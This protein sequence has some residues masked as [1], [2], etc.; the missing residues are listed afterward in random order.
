MNGFSVEELEA[1]IRGDPLT[2]IDQALQ[3][4]SK[5]GQAEMPELMVLLSEAIIAHLEKPTADDPVDSLFDHALSQRHRRF[6]AICLVRLLAVNDT[7]FDHEP[8]FRIK[9]HAL[10]DDVLAED[11]YETLGIT[12]GQQTYEKS[13][14]L[15]DA[16][17]EAESGLGDVVASLVSLDRL[18]EFREQFMRVLNTLLVRAI[19]VP[20]L[21]RPLL[22]KTRLADIF[23][24]IRDYRQAA[25]L[26][27]VDAF[28]RALEIGEQYRKEAQ[29]CNTLYCQHYLV[30]MAEKLIQLLR[31]DFA[32]NEVGQPAEVMVKS[33]EKK[34]PFH[35][36]GEDLNL[37]FVVE[38][39]GPG[40]AF[41]VELRASHFSDD[42][43]INRP[44]VYL[45]RLETGSQNVDLLAQVS[46]PE[47]IALAEIIVSWHN[48]DGST[49]QRIELFELH[50]QR[51][52]IDW[53]ALEIEDPYSLEPVEMYDDL[54]GRREIINQLVRQS[55]AKSVGSSY[56]FG[57]KRVGKTSIAK[58]LKSRLEQ[59]KDL[60][61]IYLEGGEYVHPEPEATLSR[62][63]TRLCE[64]IKRSDGRFAELAIP[65]F[66][67]AL[68][69]LVDF[70]E[71]TSEAAPDARAIFILDEFDEL[72]IELYRRGPLADAFFLTLR[73]ISGKPPFGFVLVG[74]EKMEF[75][76]SCQ[77]D[78]LNKFQ[79]M[80]VDYFDREEHWTDFQELVRRPVREW[81]EISDDAIV[82]LY[83]QTA[84]NPY[85]TMVICRELFAMMLRKRDCY[86]TGR[87]VQQAVQSALRNIRSNGF[88]HFWEDGIFESTG[89]KVEEASVRRRRILIALANVLRNQKK[90]SKEDIAKQDVVCADAD[91]LEA[92][93]RRFAQRRVLME[94]SGLYDC[95]V[96]F[97]R[98]WLESAGVREILTTFS[99]LDA[100]LE[101]RQ[102]EEQVY[103]QSEEIVNLVTHWGLYQG[104]RITEDQ[105][106]AW[107]AQFGDYISQRLMFKILQGLRFYSE[108][109]LRAKMKEAHGIVRR[110]LVRQIKARQ[111]KRGDIL[112]SYLDGPG[113]SGGGKYAKLYADENGIYYDNVVERSKLAEIVSNE[114]EGLQAIVL[115]DDFIGTGKS[116]QEYLKQLVE[117]SG[118]VLK[119]ANLKIYFIAVAGFQESQK[120]IENTI[121]DYSL[122]IDIHI[123]DPLDSSAKCFSGDSQIFPDKAERLE[124]LR[125]VHEHGVRLVK[126]NPLGYGECQSA[127]VFSDNCPNNNLPILW[128][129]SVELP[130]RPLFKRPMPQKQL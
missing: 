78:A 93:L 58:A 102:R 124:A 95:K 76:M 65:E 100:I 96:P 128:A 41:D 29:T 127:V 79:A 30:V 122:P 13:M 40:Y 88:Q 10:F 63:G 67:G 119:K 15:R 54:V 83:E 42:I 37:G 125:I 31:Q 1:E 111:R 110:G 118:H 7:Y 87:D 56:V 17:P 16:A 129:E 98:A 36:V 74:S 84:G 20:F 101:R 105:V 77:G 104:K 24:A 115:I 82:A 121:A 112:V 45:G 38:N 39:H 59:H 4:L 23:D 68:Y 66:Q 106:R 34:Y 71:S 32:H 89:N 43:T 86:V 9:A 130:W 21:P 103:V 55:R 114:G 108:D 75:I 126:R 72:P 3:A 64:K 97:F 99:D 91:V 52:D 80:P 81:F 12:Q 73:T 2:A 123:C 47:K 92:E 57:Q 19:L 70:L 53:D 11:I 60:H 33:L 25:G 69:P 85:Y 94:D 26:G 5:C 46:K 61:A 28:E 14:R 35:L 62:L 117:E 44:L 116:A 6:I 107:L 50:G 18:G 48:A 51:T 27:V 49:M 90:A 109:V 113:K 120:S 22:Y 8:D